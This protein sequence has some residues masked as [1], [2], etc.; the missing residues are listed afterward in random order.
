VISYV[1]GQRRAEIGIRMALGAQV[2]EVS[3]LIVSQSMRLAGTGVMVGLFGA[4][5]GTRLLRSLLFETSPTDPV[6]LAMTAG[7]LLVVALIASFGPTRRAAK[8]DPVEAM[9]Q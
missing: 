5:A 2:R 6:V 4:I 9:R 1:V 7:T 3:R 8:I